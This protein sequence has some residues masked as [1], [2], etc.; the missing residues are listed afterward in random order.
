V[1]GPTLPELIQRTRGDR[2]FRELREQ[3]AKFGY[4]STDTTWQQWARKDF[5]RKD[6]PSTETLRAFAAG[7]GVTETEVLLAAARTCGL[8]VGEGN[9]TDLIIPGAGVL[10]AADKNVLASLAAV[11]IAKSEH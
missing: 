1:S 10:D 11:L 9:Q 4:K 6:I 8:D 2:T 3:A 7:L 5:D